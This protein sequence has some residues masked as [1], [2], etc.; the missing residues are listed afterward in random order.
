MRTG[1]VMFQWTSLDHVALAESYAPRDAATRRSL[2]TTSTSTRSTSIQDGSLLISSRNTWTAYDL[3]PQT[4]QIKWHW[5]AST[6]ASRWGRG[7][8]T[9]WQHD[10]RELANGAFSDL[11]QRRLADRSQPVARDRRRP[12]TPGARR[13][14]RRQLTH[15]AD[16]AESQGNVQALANGDWFVGW[17]EDPR[18]LRVQPQRPAALRRALPSRRS[19]LPRPALRLD[20]R[21][22]DPAGARAG[23]RRAAAARSAGTVYASWNGATLVASWRVLV[24]T[25]AHRLRPVATASRSGFETAIVLPAGTAGRYLRC[26]R[27]AGRDRCSALPRPSRRRVSIGLVRLT[28]DRSPH[29]IAVDGR[30]RIELA[31][32]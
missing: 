28:P 14:A 2:S 3:N 17:G 13:D 1:L 31:Q 21:P 12:R 15:P 26:R 16:L 10:P 20:R 23:R 32:A 22:A 27:S 18:L 6:R 11:R 29:G 24:G 4:G 19:V 30:L 9:A 7:R 8:R 5:G 25:A